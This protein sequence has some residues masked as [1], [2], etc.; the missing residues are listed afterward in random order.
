[1]E[2]QRTKRIFK[3][4]TSS[5]GREGLR[6]P[7][8]CS[9]SKPGDHLQQ[10]SLPA[11]ASLPMGNE[12]AAQDS[13]LFLRLPI[14]EAGNVIFFPLQHVFFTSSL[15]YTAAL[16]QDSAIERSCLLSSEFPEV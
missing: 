9:R 8:A 7:Q 6:F 11:T 14:S 12:P 1:M 3:K 5:S 2:T 16:L 10:V 15:L 13:L 4:S